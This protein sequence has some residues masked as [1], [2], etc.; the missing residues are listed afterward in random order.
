MAT[1]G[2]KGLKCAVILEETVILAKRK[3]IAVFGQT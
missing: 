3:S 1:V 2:V